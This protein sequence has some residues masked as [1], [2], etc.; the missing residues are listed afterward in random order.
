MVYIGSDHVIKT[1]DFDFR[2]N[3]LRL[4]RD[5]G[6]AERNACRKTTVGILNAYRLEL[7]GLTVSREQNAA[8][9]ADVV[10]GEKDGKTSICLHSHRA[11]GA[12]QFLGAS[13]AKA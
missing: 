7:R 8:Q 11:L 6:E 12:L 10:L 2:K 3:F 5:P 9:N 1:P 13:F 4:T